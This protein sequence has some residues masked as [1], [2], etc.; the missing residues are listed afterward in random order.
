M[1]TDAQLIDLTPK[2]VQ[3]LWQQGDDVTFTV[4]FP[5]TVSMTSSTAKMVIKRSNGD[6]ALTLNMSSGITLAGQVFTVDVTKAQTAALPTEVTLYYDFQWTNAS[7][8]ERTVVSGT[9]Q[10][11]PQITS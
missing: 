6:I 3:F 2:R 7:A 11:K 1:T 4:T 10:V 9:I 5:G 8:K